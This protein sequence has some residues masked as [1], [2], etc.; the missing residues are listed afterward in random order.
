[1]KNK[2]KSTKSGRKKSAKQKI[3]HLLEFFFSLRWCAWLL[4]QVPFLA[5]LWKS[6][7]T[8]SSA[9]ILLNQ[10]FTT[11]TLGKVWD[12]A[13]NMVLG[14][15]GTILFL[16][17]LGLDWCY[18]HFP[19][20]E[21]NQLINQIRYVRS[22]PPISRPIKRDYVRVVGE[23]Q[24]EEL[25]DIGEYHQINLSSDGSLQLAMEEGRVEVYRNGQRI[26]TLPLGRWCWIP[27]EKI[28]LKYLTPTYKVQ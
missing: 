13:Y 16:I 2:G 14:K 12:I 19:T 9:G 11:G 5:E 4:L 28:Q 22:T 21:V 6:F 27:E 23:N 24:R 17:V 7:L 26:M 20:T 3:E 18:T 15:T 10:L 8:T 1:M 25:L